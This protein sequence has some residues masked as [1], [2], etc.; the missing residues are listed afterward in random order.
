MPRRRPV[1]ERIYNK[2]GDS[3]VGTSGNELI[4]LCPYCED[5]VGSPDT[6]GHLYVNSK[7]YL[8]HCFR[9]GKSGYIRP[10]GVEYEYDPVPT[11]NELYALLESALGETDRELPRYEIPRG[12]VSPDSEGGRYL[13][14]RGITPEM[15]EFYSIRQGVG[16]RRDRVIIPNQVF[17]DGRTDMFVSRYIRPIPTDANGHSAFPKYLNPPGAQKARIV[18]NL[19]RVPEGS[20]VIICEGVLSAISAGRNAVAI[21]GKSISQTQLSMILSK[22]P[23]R[24]Y[25]CLDPDAIG[26]SYKLCHRLSV[27]SAVPVYQVILPEGHDPNSLGHETFMGY[28]SRTRRFDP[29]EQSILGTVV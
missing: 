23:S 12:L 17:G 5:E 28:L 2:F 20:P 7:S 18:F 21:Y 11:D 16:N 6:K 15:V 29:V 3:V 10:S 25:V 9:C 13:E 19:H 1:D 14:S 8:Y 27:V 4:Y 24:I 26:E 22:S